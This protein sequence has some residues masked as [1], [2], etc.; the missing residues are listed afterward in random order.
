MSGAAERTDEARFVLR[1]YVTGSTTRSV[2]AVRAIRALCR[3]H[4]EGQYDLEVIDILKHPQLAHRTILQ[5]V[6]SPY[7]EVELIASGIRYAHGGAEIKRFPAMPGADTDAVLGEAGYSA[8]EI[9]AFKAAG[10]ATTGIRA[11]RKT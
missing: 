10:V 9:A 4:L 6:D 3:E 1:L 7:G 5:K 2:E 11:G 8:E